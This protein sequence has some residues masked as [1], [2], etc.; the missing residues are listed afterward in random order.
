MSV[1]IKACAA[2]ERNSLERFGDTDHR[3]RARLPRTEQRDAARGAGREH[4]HLQTAELLGGP[5]PFKISIAAA[6]TET[7]KAGV[8]L[9]RCVHFVGDETHRFGERTGCQQTRAGGGK[10][11]EMIFW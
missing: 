8:D 10:R 9:E 1:R 2:V 7:V 3:G 4:A 11:F 6:E 5:E